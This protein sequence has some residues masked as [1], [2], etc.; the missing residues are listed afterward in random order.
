M[1]TEK[2]HHLVLRTYTDTK[3]WDHLYQFAQGDKL[4]IGWKPYIDAGLANKAPSSHISEYIRRWQG[5][6]EE[7]IELYLRNRDVSG[8][9]DTAFR[10]KDVAKLR[11]MLLEYQLDE[12]QQLIQVYLQKLNA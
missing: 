3:Q 5:R 2:F 9:A 12:H 10:A 6:P 1:A 8:A 7:K 11:E 4:P